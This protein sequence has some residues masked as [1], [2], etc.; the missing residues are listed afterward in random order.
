MPRLPGGSVIKH[1]PA[2]AEDKGSIPDP[3]R[4]HMLHTTD[5]CSTTPEPLLWGPRDTTTVCYW[6]HALQ[7]RPPQWEAHAPQLVSGPTRPN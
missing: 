6:A 7:E 1:P 3:G 5:L 4:S 2:N